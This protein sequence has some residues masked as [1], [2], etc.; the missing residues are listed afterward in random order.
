M[1]QTLGRNTLWYT[2]MLLGTLAATQQLVSSLHSATISRG[3][4]CSLHLPR[5]P[6][7]ACVVLLCGAS[8][9]HFCSLIPLQMTVEIWCWTIQ[10]KM[11]INKSIFLATKNP[12]I[13]IWT[14]CGKV[15]GFGCELGIRNNTSQASQSYLGWTHHCIVAQR[16]M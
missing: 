4:L 1:K 10:S 16:C 6:S 15:R 11:I 8:E 2:L 13:Q 12:R 9:G 14:N 3:S 5:M 7:F